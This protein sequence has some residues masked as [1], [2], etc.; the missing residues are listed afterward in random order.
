MKTRD[1]FKITK[2]GIKKQRKNK[3]MD[4]TFVT[5]FYK[6]YKDE[7]SEKYLSDFVQFLD[8]NY[9]T[10]L[11][12]D[13]TITNW[14][15]TLANYEN[16][17]LTVINN[18]SF[19]SLMQ[20]KPT[21]LPNTR[22]ETKDT[23]N[24]LVLM[25]SKTYFASIAPAKTKYLAWIDFGISRILKDATAAYTR[26]KYITIPDDKILIPGCIEKG[27]VNLNHVNWRFCGGLFFGTKAAIE[28]MHTESST[29]LKAQSQISWEV[30]IWALVD[31][32]NPDLFQWYK[33]D[34][35]DTIFSYPIKGDK[36]VIVTLMIKN[37]QAIINRCLNHA[38]SIA[39]AICISDTGSTDET[40]NILN[41]YIKTAKIPIKVCNHVWEDFGRNRTLS[42]QESQT[43]CKELGW[44]S[45]LTYGLLLDADMNF[46]QLPSFNKTQLTANGYRIKQKSGSLEYYNT[47]FVKLGYPW[48]CVGVTHEYWDGADTNSLDTI[49][50]D[51]IGD[52]GSK[53]DK[54]PRD[55]RL[56]RKGLEEDPTNARYMF[57]LAQTLK[58]M[59]K[60]PEAIELY[61]RRVNAGGW[62]EEI[63]YS[64]YMIGRLYN[65]LN[66]KIEME[67]WCL[68]AYEMNKKRAENIYYLAKTFREMGQNHKAWHYVE[69]GSKLKMT[70]DMLFVETDVYTHLFDYERTILNYYINPHENKRS[71]A[72]LIKYYNDQGGHVYSNLQFYVEPLKSTITP[73]QFPEKGDFVPTSTSFL[74]QQ[75]G[76]YLLNVRYVN[77]RIQ[78]DG[79][80]L[81]MKNSVLSRDNKVITRNFT[82][83]T[84]SKF[85]PITELKEMLTDFSPKHQVYI[86][87]LEDL[88]LYKNQNNE[89][90]WIATSME[91]SHDGKIRQIT[92]KYNLD[93]YTLQNADSLIPP[94]P[95]DC[96]K[97]WIPI[98]NS[99]LIIYGWKPYRIGK[100]VDSHF[101]STQVQET[102]RYFE[103][104][105]GSSNIV[106]YNGSLW[107]LTH[108]VMYVNPRKYYH[109]LMRLNK[110]TRKIESYSLPFYF[111]TNHIEYCLGIDIQGEI[112]TAIVSQNDANPILVKASL[113]DFT[114]VPL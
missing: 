38:I 15:N 8:F 49:Y 75:D 61:K 28:T 45:E 97:N 14:Q 53:S 65:E 84:D 27:T 30:N 22:N 31:Q 13:P 7:P 80:Y 72:H 62:Y 58:D 29:L 90:H 101:V 2:S 26:L 6:V 19:E 87:G 34:H 77:Y 96:E 60:L 25:N 68:K 44:N 74:R 110:I 18:I 104:V 21:A 47:R 48:K 9:P 83:V 1:H 52:G 56:L 70:T 71:L 5:A 93:T 105:R 54:F 32:I 85:A 11:Y 73:L 63:W 35:N 12:L 69:L 82:T 43:Y 59:K 78:H 91:Y 33:G 20:D 37:E 108:I 109:Q 41:T 95:S 89:L 24:Y 42:F 102:P 50:I 39:D 23:F 16:K 67:Y 92:G 106:E 66:D 79:S 10:I 76:T 46:V 40:L 86:E 113:G 99:E 3:L 55:E 36:K 81:M 88:R 111:R 112:L 98:E 51:D 103:H 114:F 94:Q 4:L 57:Y 17:N 107:T 64:M 100:I